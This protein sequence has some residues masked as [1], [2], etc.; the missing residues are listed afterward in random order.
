MPLEPA[1]A[2]ALYTCNLAGAE[3]ESP[4]IRLSYASYFTPPRVYDY[5]LDGGVLT[6]RKEREVRG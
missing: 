3:F 6:L 1:F 4:V 2:E 5:L